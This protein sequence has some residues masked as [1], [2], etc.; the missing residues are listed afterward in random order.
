MQ[1]I[2][3]ETEYK[4]ARRHFL[5]ISKKTAKEAN[6]TEFLDAEDGPTPQK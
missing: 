2:A 1:E 6:D 5:T 3:L 4:A